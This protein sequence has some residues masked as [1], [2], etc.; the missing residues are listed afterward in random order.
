MKYSSTLRL[1]SLPITSER[2]HSVFRWSFDHHE[3]DAIIRSY[4]Q[5]YGIEA[6]VA[7]KDFV[8]GYIAGPHIDEVNN[9]ISCIVEFYTIEA[10]FAARTGETQRQDGVV[11]KKTY[12]LINFHENIVTL[13]GEK[14]DKIQGVSSIPNP[15][16]LSEF[17]VLSIYNEIMLIQIYRTQL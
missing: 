2:S 14:V 13:T 8:Y 4:Q 17:A 9:A 7:L 3:A 11:I 16:Q 12:G 6:T 1:V 15:K 5:H 10:R